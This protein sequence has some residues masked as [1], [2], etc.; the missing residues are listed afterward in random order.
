LRSMVREQLAQ[1]MPVTGRLTCFVAI[2][3]PQK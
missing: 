2:S 1:V 3:H